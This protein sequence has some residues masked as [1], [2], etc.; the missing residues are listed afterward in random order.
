MNGVIQ[1]DDWNAYDAADAYDS[2]DGSYYPPGYR[3]EDRDNP[4]TDSYYSHSRM[5]RRNLLG[6]DL[7]IIAKIGTI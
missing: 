3:W 6:S 7:G 2:Y 5:V 1:D 4:C